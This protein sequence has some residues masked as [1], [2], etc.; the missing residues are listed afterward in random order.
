MIGKYAR[1]FRHL[2]RIVGSSKTK[3]LFILQNGRILEGEAFL[4]KTNDSTRDILFIFQNMGGNSDLIKIPTEYRTIAESL[5]QRYNSYYIVKDICNLY[6]LGRKYFVVNDDFNEQYD[7]FQKNNKKLLEQVYGKYCYS[8][9]SI[10]SFMFAIIGNAPNLYVWALTNFFKNNITL[11]TI[12]HIINWQRKYSQLNNKLSKGT[13]TAYNGR[14]K[15]NNLVNEIVSLRSLKRANDSINS[16]NTAQKKLLKGIELNEKNTCILNRF[17]R[18][19]KQKKHN[20]IRKMS[21]IEDVNDILHQ[22]SLLS[23]V[24]FEWNRESLIDFI[25]NSENIKCDIVL[26]ENNLVLVKVKTYD[27]VKLLAKTTNWCISKNKRYW[28]DYIEHRQNSEQFVLFDFNKP[29]D[30]ELSIVGFT[31]AKDN[32]ITNA[33]SFSNN[34]LMGRNEGMYTRLDT[35]MKQTCNNSIYGIIKEN[36]IPINKILNFNKLKY[37]WN[38]NSFLTYLNYYIDE[39]FYTIHSLYEDEGG[40]LVFSTKHEN[41]KYIIDN[42]NFNNMHYDMNNLEVFVF[43]DFSYDEDDNEKLRYS[44]IYNNGMTK[45]EYSSQMYDCY[46]STIDTTFEEMLEMFHLPY[47]TICR[48]NDNVKRFETAFRNYDI[49]TLKQFF[50][51]SKIIDEVKKNSNRLFKQSS[52]SCVYSSIF[53]FRSFDYINLIY[54]N[55]Y[56]LIDF[57]DSKY[58]EDILMSL[59]YEITN[60]YRTF[61]RIPT[62]ND[63]ERFYN[64]EFDSRQRLVIGYFIILDKIMKN[65]DYIHY[66]VRLTDSFHGLR[67]YEDFDV[68]LLKHIISN[69]SFNKLTSRNSIYLKTLATSYNYNKELHDIFLS[70]KIGED[71]MNYINQYVPTNS[72]LYAKINEKSNVNVN[73]FA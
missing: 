41:I 36:K 40:Q 2:K 29:E 25:N 31:S 23:N 55:G 57:I 7:N 63:I 62:E 27:T 68:Y 54:D 67:H 47:D 69:M 56:K 14:E 51:N 39:D 12:E 53:D 65:E 61:G 66:G 45:E 17:G 10:A 64:N 70:K 72:S 28:N 46:G 43:M 49:K 21:T 6:Q 60:Y 5:L 71:C 38:L 16:F 34:N 19:S 33:H 13:V 50:A 32:G 30:H 22:M 9:D 73:V 48:T 11:Y 8:S 18:L 42:N 26:D 44:F 3:K 1:G 15:I 35:F 24:H 52:G 59:V 58:I 37:K 4:C 20:F